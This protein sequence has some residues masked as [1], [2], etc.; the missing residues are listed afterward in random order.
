MDSDSATFFSPAQRRVIAFA[1]AFAALA[2]TAVLLWL[3]IVA[4]ARGVA[5][6]SGVLWPLAV[7]G[8]AAL[9]IRP[10]VSFLE[11]RLKLARPVS[12]ALLFAAVFLAF[13]GAA[14]LVLPRILAQLIGFITE[15]PSLWQRAA[16]WSEA[17]YPQWVELYD[18]Y[19]EN[20]TARRVVESVTAQVQLLAENSLPNLVSATGQ[21]FGIFG[22][23]AGAAVIP[24]YLFYFLQTDEAPT[25]NLE[26]NLPFLSPSMREDVVFLAQEFLN[27]VVAFFR[28]QLLIGLIMGA[29]LAVGFGV[30]GLNFG[31]G[32]GFTL[33][34]LNV[35]PYLGTII[36]LL[37]TIPTAYFQTDGG[38][39]LVAAVLGVFVVVQLIE[40]YLLTP[41]I[42]GQ[43]TG[44]HPVTIIVAI[45][46]WGTALNGILGMILAIPLTAF[47][48]TTWRLAKRK[49]FAAVPTRTV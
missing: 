30:A 41:R 37:L 44:L 47:F 23:L 27:I 19:M 48:V 1:G 18:R 46:F 24:I 29:L 10:L 8:I 14:Y 17:N 40:S 4:L 2:A 16:T 26:S 7:A 34:L 31:I 20:E 38:L 49:Y 22:L 25:K 45:F 9:M 15:A 5:L 39:A 6:F 36:G 35:V 3:V 12:V 11:R 13:I 42:L 43:N 21:V 28:G 32:L 33:G